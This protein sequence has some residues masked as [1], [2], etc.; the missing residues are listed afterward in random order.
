VN[1]YAVPEGVAS[2]RTH[3]ATTGQLEARISR[4]VTDALAH[5]AKK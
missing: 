3:C 1:G 4:M 5:R 2:N